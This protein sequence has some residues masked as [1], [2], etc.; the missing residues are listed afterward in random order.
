MPATSSRLERL[1]PA[2]AMAEELHH[3]AAS[4]TGTVIFEHDCRIDT[5]HLHDGGDGRY[6]THHDGKHEQARCQQGRHHDR[7]P[8]VDGSLTMTKLTV[9]AS[10]KP[11]TALSSAWQMMTL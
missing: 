5:Q 7:Q 4:M 10:K 6:D 3:V 8:G 9:A 2:R 11:M 1:H